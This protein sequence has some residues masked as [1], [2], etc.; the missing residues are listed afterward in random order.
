MAAQ[1][2]MTQKQFD[3][4]CKR[5]GFE[6]TG[7]F[8]GYYKL[9]P[10]C[11]NV[12]VSILNAGSNRRAQLAYLIKEQAKSEKRTTLAAAEPKGE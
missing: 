1:R 12:H 11:D 10:P 2:D 4:A 3:E 7:G 9:A 5:Y 6:S 8:M